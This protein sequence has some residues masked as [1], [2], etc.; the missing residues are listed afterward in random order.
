MKKF[1]A[2]LV[3]VLVAGLIYLT[4]FILDY[5]GGFGFTSFF[6]LAPVYII[7]GHIVFLS[8]EEIL[9]IKEDKYD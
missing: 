4:S 6:S 3:I 2:G 7:L 5:M 9:G 1:I 8:G